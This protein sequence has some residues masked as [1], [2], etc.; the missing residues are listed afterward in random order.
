MP[1]FAAAAAASAAALGVAAWAE[2]AGAGVE[3]TPTLIVDGRY[4]ITATTHE[5]GLRI[6]NQLIAQ[7]RAQRRSPSHP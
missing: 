4:R 2:V 5:A 7:L 3:G 6:A 1:E